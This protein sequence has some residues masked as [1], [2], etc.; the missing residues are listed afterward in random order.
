MSGKGTGQDG[1]IT[2]GDVRTALAAGKQARLLLRD[3]VVHGLYLLAGRRGAQWWVEYKPPGRDQD[4]RRH[5]T[6]HFKL[7]NVQALSPD[8][9][10]QAAAQVKQG[11]LNGQDPK[12]ARRA[13]QRR[14]TAPGWAGVRDDY[15][16][17]LQRRLTNPRSRQNEVSYIIAVF[18]LLDP[19]RPLRELNLADIHR[20]ID[21]LP[22]EGVLARQR[23]A[24]LG[25]LLDW[26]RSRDITDMPNPVRL[27]PRGAR[28]RNPPPR[29]RALSLSELRSL[30]FGAE[31]LAP[32][33]CRLLRMLIAVPLRKG[34]VST[35]EWHWIDRAAGAITLP[36]RT[37]KNGEDHSIPLGRL[38]RQTLDQISNGDAWPISGRVFVSANARVA[39]WSSFKQHIDAVVPLSAPWVFHDFRRSFVSALAER[40]H[41]EAVLDQMLA[42]RASSTRS[43]VLGVY[44]ISKQLPAQRRAMAEWDALLAGA[45][46]DESNVLPLQA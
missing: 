23:L 29:Q 13:A 9:A 36:G 46:T 20:L 10:R 24:A 5:S 16:A 39:E 1:R 12:A 18:E 30:W 14:A 4:G 38:A 17:H 33:E 3:G 28:P 22:R 11:V 34:E 42:H 27:L 43:G 15:L 2:L 32:F 19:R 25:R 45:D 44:Q 41:A 26:A 7:G 35:L 6:R 8:S 40:G 37:M 31:K 21:Q